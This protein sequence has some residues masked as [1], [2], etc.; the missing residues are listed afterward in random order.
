MEND[1]C[2]DPDVFLDAHIEN[3][4]ERNNR[5]WHQDASILQEIAAIANGGKILEYAGN[6]LKTPVFVHDIEETDIYGT[7]QVIQVVFE[8]DNILWGYSWL[9][10]K[11][12]NISQHE[13]SRLGLPTAFNLVDEGL[14]SE[15]NKEKGQQN[16]Y[17]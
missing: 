15:A 7:H 5:P 1:P 3:E 12:E 6:I 16:V 10:A 2:P 17:E 9:R 13:Y 14:H 4:Q 8:Y 11:N